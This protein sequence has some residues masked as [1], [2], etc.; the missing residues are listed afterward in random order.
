MLKPADT[1]E[2]WHLGVMDTFTERCPGVEA[3]WRLSAQ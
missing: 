3:P 1:N 2:L